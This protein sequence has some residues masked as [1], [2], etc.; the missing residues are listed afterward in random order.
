MLYPFT[1]IYSTY[2]IEIMGS[3]QSSRV[4]HFDKD[5]QQHP[6]LRRFIIGIIDVQNDFCRGG[7][8]PVPEADEI[9]AGINKLRYMY[10]N[11]IKTFLSQDWHDENHMSFAQT[12]NKQPFTGPETLRLAMEDESIITV[13]QMMWPRH[14]IENTVGSYLHSDLITNKNDYF[15]K[16]G[17]KINVESYS[18]FG[19]EFQ[20]KYER[21]KLNAWLKALGIT[22]IIL[23]G[24]ASDY[25]VYYTALDAIR[26]Y[27]RVHII[28][29]CTRGVKKET[30]DKAFEDLRNKGVRF[31]KNV[32]LFHQA[33][34]HFIIK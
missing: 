3:N 18:A 7:K 4:A 22:D 29:S 25:C 17:T 13:Q 19:D 33:N 1:S 9:I 14:C 8:L 12:H 28:L 27:Y 6:K 5:K 10:D 2:Q 32:D 11:Y 23:T 31:Y 16:K 21:T 15:V 30:T 26:L 24:V 34:E 20:G